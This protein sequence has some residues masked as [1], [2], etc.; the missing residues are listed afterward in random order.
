MVI[1]VFQGSGWNSA[2][3]NAV[4]VLEDKEGIVLRFRDKFYQTMGP[5]PDGGGQQTT[6]YG[7]FVLSRSGKTVVLEED[8]QN[9]KGQPPVWKKRAGLP[10]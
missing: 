2:G 10:K 6:V 1:A 8:V 3:L 5:G 9:I 7:F 4:A